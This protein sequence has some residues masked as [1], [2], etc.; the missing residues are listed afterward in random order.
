[1]PKASSGYLHYYTERFKH[2]ELCPFG[3][4]VNTP[5]CTCMAVSILH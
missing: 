3:I 2:G 1:V 4:F 5:L